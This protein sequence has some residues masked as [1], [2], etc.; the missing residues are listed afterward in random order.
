MFYIFLIYKTSDEGS[1][2]VFCVLNA[3][4]LAFST[5]DASVLRNQFP[6]VI[7]HNIILNQ[8]YQQTFPSFI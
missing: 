6:R 2:L 4:N 8:V 1:F 5:L 7:W 3:K